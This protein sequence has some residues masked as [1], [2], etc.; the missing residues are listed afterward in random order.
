MLL[1]FVVYS[2]FTHLSTVLVVG[3][4]LAVCIQQQPQYSD[5]LGAGLHLPVGTSRGSLENKKYKT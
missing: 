5:T 1:C 2:V 3:V 4:L